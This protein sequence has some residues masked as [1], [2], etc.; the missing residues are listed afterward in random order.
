M[1]DKVLILTPLKDAEELLEGYFARLYQLTYPA[2]L[3]SL[4]FLESD[5]ADNTFA[6]VSQRLPELNQCFRSA[7][8]WKKDFGFRLPP[9]VPRWRFGYQL[10]RRTVLAKSRNHLLFH[11]LD[12]E[13]WV[14]WMDVDVMEYPVDIIER[15]LATGKD[16][17]TPHCVKRYGGRS[18][19]LNSWRDKGRLHLHDLRGEGD[20]VRLHAVGA[21]MLW[22]KA[23]IHR[24]GLIFPP[25]LY[26]KQSSL[27][28]WYNH[29]VPRRAV[30]RWREKPFRGEIETEGLGIMAHDMGYECWGLPNLEVIHRDA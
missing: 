27:I 18:F 1:P 6:A 16:I 21:T 5:S 11:A 2:Q 22:V 15:F 24:D 14:L 30:I 23:D 20:L 19:D 7:R 10:P 26:G 8:L 28:R 3:I 13:D 9:G 17:V 4:G 25:F 12:D 29:L